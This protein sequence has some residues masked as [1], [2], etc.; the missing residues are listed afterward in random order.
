MRLRWSIALLALVCAAAL[1]LSAG[2]LSPC[3]A[4][5]GN[6][7]VNCGFETGDFSGWTTGGNF[8]ATGVSSS[9]Y[10]YSAANSGTYFAYLGPVGSD[11]ILS[12]TL[13][14]NPGDTYTVSFY[15]DAIGDSPS[16]F[17]AYW[18]TDALMSVGTPN[19]GGVWTQY[20]FTVTGT[21]SDTIQLNF[22]DDPAYI[23]LDDIVVLDTGGVIPEP[24]SMSLLIAGFAVVILA[25]RRRRA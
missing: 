19:T 5:A 7:V 22:R 4:Q 6:L 12:R 14:T 2:S 9:F 17:S 10:V 13:T 15:L 20:L 11:G 8:G 3:G 25:R 24:G 21:G 16:D 18:N 1:P 23:A